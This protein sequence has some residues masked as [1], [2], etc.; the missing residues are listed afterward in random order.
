MRRIKSIIWLNLEMLS[1]EKKKR[2]EEDYVEYGCCSIQGSDLQKLEM[3]FEYDDTGGNYLDPLAYRMLELFF[4]KLSDDFPDICAS[5]SFRHESRKRNLEKGYDDHGGYLELE[6]LDGV[7]YK[8]EI[9]I[10]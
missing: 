4:L 8:S 3:D 1:A 7:V 6:L 10:I 2:F 5:A 9:P